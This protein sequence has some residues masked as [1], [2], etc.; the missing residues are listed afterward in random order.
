MLENKVLPEAYE[1]E[2]E[3]VMQRLLEA[4]HKLLSP[5]NVTT[6]P[7]KAGFRV[8]G[9][10]EEWVEEPSIEVCRTCFRAD[11]YLDE[12]IR[13]KSGKKRVV[14]GLKIELS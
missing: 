14:V 13:I 6:E 4:E 7:K 12:R 9:I 3:D 5:V 1:Q 8:V 11:C 10:I 2:Y